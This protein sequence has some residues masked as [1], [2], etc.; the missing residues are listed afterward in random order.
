MARVKKP[1]QGAA[2]GAS[3]HLRSGM[4]RKESGDVL[5]R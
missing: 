5:R 2:F 1:R 4:E 3:T